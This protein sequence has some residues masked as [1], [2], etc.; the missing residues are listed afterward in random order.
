MDVNLRALIDPSIDVGV[1]GGAAL[2]DFSD[3]LLGPNRVALDR[4]RTRLAQ[5]LGLPAVAGAAAVAANF[6]KND[7][8]ANGCGIP[9]DPAILKITKDIR[10]DL[11]LNEFRSAKNTFQHFADE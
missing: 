1:A 7:R 5:E 9:I 4:A 8:I 10:A 6:S 3:T 2:L 11:G